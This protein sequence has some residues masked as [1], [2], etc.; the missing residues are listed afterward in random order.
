[1]AKMT[2][3]FGPKEWFVFVILIILL[4]DLVILLDI[5]FLR[6]ILGFFLLTFLPGLL[7]L[8]ILK[9]DKLNRVE[10]LLYSIGLSIAF[11]MFTG[12]T[13]NMLYPTFGI[14]KPLSTLP[15]MITI[16]IILLVM[17]IISYL[18]NKDFSISIPIN[19]K[20]L[21]SPSVLLLVLLPIMSIL[22]MCIVNF[23]G[24][25][26]ILLFLIILISAIVVLAAFEIIPVKY[27]PL[28]IVTIALALV[29]YGSLITFYI[30]G[31]WN[32]I[33][34]EFY[35]YNL[36]RAN[37]YWD[38]TIY[39]NV[40]AMLS[41][42]ILPVI[43]SKVL[44]IAGEWVYRIIYPLILAFVPLTLYQVYQKLTDAKIAFLSTF[45]F[46]AMPTFFT[47]LPILS[48]MCIAEL[49]FALLILLLIKKNIALLKRAMLSIIC[50]LSLAV[51]HYGTSYFYMFY[52]LGF[53]FILFV[54]EKGHINHFLG[55]SR[56]KK[57]KY[58]V[59]AGEEIKSMEFHSRTIT[60][61]FVLIYVTFALSWYMYMSSSSAFNA[62]VHISD[63]IY[64]SIFIDFLNPTA[65]EAS[66][67]MALGMGPTAAS[68]WHIINRYIWNITELFIIVGALS[69]IIK[70]RE[71]KFEYEYII[72]LF[73]SG[74]LLVMC[75]FLPFF[76]IYFSMM[77]IYHITLF[78]LAPCCII[79]GRNIF[80]L[81]SKLLKR[82]YKPLGKGE[83]S[84]FALTT[85]LLIILI[86]FFL[87][88]SGV[89]FSFTEDLPPCDPL[90]AEKYKTSND[91]NMTVH[92][93]AYCIPK[94]DFIS[95][96]WLSVHKNDKST[97]YTGFTS[98]WYLLTPYPLSPSEKISIIKYPNQSIKSDA[99]IYLRDFN[100]KS[101]KII[102]SRICEQGKGYSYSYYNI[103]EIS[104]QLYDE[105]R[106]YSNGGSEIY[107]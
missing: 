87:F 9:L 66:T 83:K 10:T 7:I 65:R 56:N 82:V 96:K 23:Y 42:T 99:F 104:S 57:K 45:F 71:L 95:A 39:G 94:E 20:E 76:S 98:K 12:F 48:R 90:S 84:R 74:I 88:N 34:T 79:G 101:N 60:K 73:I 46:M 22:G 67:W 19:I 32:D 78:F 15:L 30:A 31:E 53:I 103:T 64:S 35:Y 68:L 13:I 85:F 28:A 18:G 14:S 92:Y 1:M 47:M 70:R 41:V 93:L 107:R 24:N 4:A 26:Y 8:Q 50:A 44:N 59:T 51:S 77:R 100:I 106:I 40:N 33:T 97:I 86:P 105:N 6:Q 55:I 2:L 17:S 63:H 11:L 37:S 54:V 102:T 36:V 16:S 27:Y 80:R 72:M 81:I 91:I 52:I 49:Y 69:L 25:N 61:T 29:F 3:K 62:I 58:W 89:I 75:I 21:F 43:F 38:S 5:Q